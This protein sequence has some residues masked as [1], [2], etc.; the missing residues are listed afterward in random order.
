M[1]TRIIHT[2]VHRKLVKLG[3]PRDVKQL[4]NYLISN[5]YINLSGIYELPDAYI[6]METGM[7]QEEIDIAK[8]WLAD[9]KK[10]GFYKG[11]VCLANSDEHNNY[12]RSVTT[13]KAYKKEI[14]H[15]PVS[16]Q[17]YF[18]DWVCGYQDSTTNS[19]IDSKHN[20][21]TINQK[22]ETKNNNPESLNQDSGSLNNNL[23]RDVKREVLNSFLLG[24]FLLSSVLFTKT[25]VAKEK[26]VT[27]YTVKSTQSST[28]SR[29]L[30]SSKASPTEDL[31]ARSG[32]KQKEISSSDALA[33]IPS[34]EEWETIAKYENAATIAQIYRG[35]S[36]YGAYDACRRRGMY[37]GFGFME[38]N[39]LKYGPTCFSTFETVVSKV[40]D[41]IN[42]RLNEGFTKKQ[43]N[44][45]DITGRAV[46]YCNTSYKL[47]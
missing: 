41:W 21:E 13:E 45:Y 47:M 12:K 16:V 32:Q 29:T 46:E 38:P 26:I 7:T 4:F 14:S 3:A 44:C 10:V 15:I 24:I 40:N 1:K 2:N 18:H 6:T 35:E 20:T 33:L 30:T 28:T 42:A 5:E 31:S 9:R 37:N 17:Q 27:V 23:E 36:N 11:W 39:P 25:A 22:P 43:M 8:K 19:T 34:S